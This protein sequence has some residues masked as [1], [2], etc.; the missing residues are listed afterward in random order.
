METV[1]K[2]LTEL[3][4]A[5]ELFHHYTVRNI[6]ARYVQADEFWSYC[7]AKNKNVENIKRPGVLKAGDVWTWNAIDTASRLII[8]WYTGDR[9][10]DSAYLFLADLRSRLKGPVMIATDSL[11]AYIDLIPEIF[12]EAVLHA[13][14]LKKVKATY[15]DVHNAYV[16]RQHLTVRMSV[17]R[18][19][20][21]TNAF[22]KKFERHGNS[23][24][25]YYVY[26]NFVRPHLTLSTNSP[27]TPAMAAGLTVEPYT[28]SWVLSLIEKYEDEI[29][30]TPLT[31][32][33]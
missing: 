21:A 7:Y 31:A 28:Y 22:S 16:E 24:A 10:Y 6:E 33:V 32:E 14:L 9:D 23:L 12:G 1:L 2:L 29:I 17:K 11:D 26:Y 5:C 25:L 15:E 8:S 13:P 27:V 4:A 18:F 20:R 19:T 30:N 3:G